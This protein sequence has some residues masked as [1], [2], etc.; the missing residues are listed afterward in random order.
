[1]NSSSPRFEKAR[2]AKREGKAPTTQAGEDCVEY[3]RK[4]TWEKRK[5]ELADPLI[6]ER[7][8]IAEQHKYLSLMQLVNSITA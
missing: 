6:K 1:L 5:G 3:K 4:R 7:K 8:N 2:K